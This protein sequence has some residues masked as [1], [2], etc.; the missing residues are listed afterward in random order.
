MVAE[1]RATM[2]TGRQRS[3]GSTSTIGSIHGP[4][5]MV[6]PSEGALSATG[7]NGLRRCRFPPN[8]SNRTE[9]LILSNSDYHHRVNITRRVISNFDYANRYNSGSDY[10]ELLRPSKFVLCPSGMGWDT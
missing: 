3:I 4:A 5:S 6:R 2:T 8:M 9:L 1:W 10:L 7:P